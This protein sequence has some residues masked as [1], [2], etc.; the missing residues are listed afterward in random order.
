MPERRAHLSVHAGRR[1]RA[2]VLLLPGGQASG[3]VPMTVLDP[4]YLRMLPFAWQLRTVGRGRIAVATLRY[5]SRSWDG[6]GPPLREAREALAQ[7][8]LRFPQWPIV[9]LGHSMGGRVAL[10][11]AGEPGVS[12]V[13][14]LAPWLPEGPPEPVD[15][16]AGRRVLVLH[17]GADRI[18]DPDASARYVARAQ[19]AGTDARLHRLDGLEHTMLWRP[20]VWHR[21]AGA[22]VAPATSC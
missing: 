18:T 20:D 17:G 6:E 15:Q 9:L 11:A 5:A 16:L 8:R 19:A 1:C 7:L 12:S 21:L 3:D 22:F 10:R 14:A 13:L 4:A 2:L